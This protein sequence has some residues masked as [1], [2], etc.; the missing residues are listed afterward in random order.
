MKIFEIKDSEDLQ[1]CTFRVFKFSSS[2][3]FEILSFWFVQ[4]CQVCD[5]LCVESC[6]FITFSITI[7]K[8]CPVTN[9]AV[10]CRIVM[11]SLCDTRAIA[12]ISA[13]EY[14][15]FEVYPNTLCAFDGLEYKNHQT[16]ANNSS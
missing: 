10:L 15:N 7:V 2:R 1:L 5:N 11:F 9:A 8:L 3:V 14:V 4:S 12:T 16:L 6:L 13:S